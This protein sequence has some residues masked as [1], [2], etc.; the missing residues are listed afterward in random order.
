MNSTIDELISL[1]DARNTVLAH[2]HHVLGLYHS[3]LKERDW[4]AS[5]VHAGELR[6]LAFALGAAGHREV[7]PQ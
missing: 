5:D 1:K 6:G 2:Y 3:A 7:L 4:K